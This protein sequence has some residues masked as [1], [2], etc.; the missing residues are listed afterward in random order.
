MCV[1]IRLRLQWLRSLARFLE[2]RFVR[3]QSNDRCEYITSGSHVRLFLYSFG[4]GTDDRTCFF[5]KLYFGIVSH[6]VT[7]V[8]MSK[9][10]L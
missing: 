5:G 6:A 2:E 7:Q 10:K 9:P 3:Y 4:I 8:V 1:N